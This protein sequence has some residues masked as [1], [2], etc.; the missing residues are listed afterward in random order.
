MASLLAEFGFTTKLAIAAF[1][2]F[3]PFLL[4]YTI[5]ID[6]QKNCNLQQKRTLQGSIAT[7]HWAALLHESRC[8]SLAHFS[9]G[10]EPQFTF[11]TRQLKRFL[12]QTTFSLP[13]RIVAPRCGER[14]PCAFLLRLSH[15]IASWEIHCTAF[16]GW[17]HFQAVLCCETQ[18]R[19]KKSYKDFLSQCFKVSPPA[20]REGDKWDKLSKNGRKKKGGKEKNKLGER[21]LEPAVCGAKNLTEQR[22]L[23]LRVSELFGRC[24]IVV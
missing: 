24:A 17:V 1:G 22:L 6:V 15:C 5:Y 23:K 16:E 9:P 19:E 10:E 11:V 14:L 20:A 7:E 2:V 21:F 13:S 12:A 8:I 4:Q 3:Q 18:R